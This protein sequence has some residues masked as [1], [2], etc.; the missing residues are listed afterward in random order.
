MP[1]E[2]RN[3]YV[4]KENLY[5][6]GKDLALNCYFLSIPVSNTMVD[7]EE[8]YRIDEDQYSIF[9]KDSSSAK[10]FADECRLRQHDQLL[11]LKP[12]KDRGIPR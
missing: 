5:S 4:S 2:I 1:N 7:Y 12:G 11:T 6:I 9:M 8:F 3:D 10:T